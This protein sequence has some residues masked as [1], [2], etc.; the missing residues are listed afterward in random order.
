MA[1]EL[2]LLFSTDDSGTPRVRLQPVGLDGP[3]KPRDRTLDFAL[4]PDD[5][6]DLKWYLEEYMDLPDHGSRVRARGIEDRIDAWGRR[7]FDEVFGSG[8]QQKLM[9][10]LLAADGPRL[11][12]V[13]TDD[14]A[15]LRLP[16][17]MLTNSTS[18]LYRK[19]TLRRQLEDARESRPVQVELPLR[20]LL[21]VSRPDDLGF[22]DPRMTTRQ[23]GFRLRERDAWV[24]WL[25]QAAAAPWSES[26]ASQERDAAWSLLT[27]GQ[28]REALQ[29]LEQLIKRLEQTTEFDPAFQLATARLQ[30]GRA[31]NATGQAGRAI[32][33]LRANVRDWEALCL[34]SW[35]RESSDEPHH[36]GRILT[37][38]A[39]EK[40]ADFD[41]AFIASLLQDESRRD[42]CRTELGN[43]AATLGDLANAMRNAGQLD[44]ALAAA[45]QGADINAAIGQH[46]NHAAGLVRTAQI[47]MQQGHY[48]EADTEYDR[49]LSAARR[50]GDT[51]LQGTTLQHQ[52]SLA[53]DRRQYSRAAAL[54]QQ[55]LNLFQASGD[56]ENIMRT[57]NLLGVVEQKQGR[58]AEARA[59]YERSREIAREREDSQSLGVAA[60]NLGIVCQHEG[61]AARESG[62]EAAAL[63]HFTAAERFLQES[64]QLRLDRG[65]EPAE[66][67]A[68]GQLGQLYRL[69]G[70]LDEAE[71][72]AQRA[73]E[74][75]E[76]LGDFRGLSTVYM[77]LKHIAEA[78][79]DAAA[80]GVWAEKERDVDAK[81]E[82]RA[83]GGGEADGSRQMLE[84]LAQLLVG[85]VQ[86]AATGMPL[87]QPLAGL[88]DQLDNP[89]AGD[90]APL[91]AWFRQLTT[92]PEP[93]LLR[94]LNSPPPE[95]PAP[96]AAIVDQLKDALT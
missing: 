31:Y 36:D 76:G 41:A 95:L 94:Q 46:R 15:V 50:A 81:L 1:G 34:R 82:R 70:R 56:A 86:S 38:P 18:P 48:D 78:R 85:C 21:V 72:H 27:Q 75:M 4:D 67:E 44:P 62:D 29:R 68:Q 90:L 60:Q 47:L 17:E 40:D 66:A 2:R 7:L 92:T 22:I 26:V 28:A 53:D 88:L 43:L 73:R 39:T 6:K 63:R 20:I 25:A 96:L 35:T 77:Y 24:A 80:A 89:D 45:R 12:T 8:S 3:Q 51:E 32:P 65:D 13:A 52:G 30:L 87:P 37:N 54:Y 23:F 74:T 10:A 71:Q 55:A 14:A 61:E 57:C 84:L 11:L 69:M 42:T 59:W 83:H 9:D 58:L 19:V 5:D 64:L 49:A 93:E 16:W 91:G 79:G 33:L